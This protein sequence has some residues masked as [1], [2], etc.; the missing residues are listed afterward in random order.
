M[1][2][3]V[4]HLYYI[5]NV[6]ILKTLILLTFKSV[7]ER[8]GFEPSVR[9][10]RTLAFQASALNHSAISPYHYKVTKKQGFDLVFLAASPGKVYLKAWN[11]WVMPWQFSFLDLGGAQKVH[12]VQLFLEFLSRFEYFQVVRIQS[13]LDRWHSQKL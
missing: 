12:Q 2:Q 9:Y 7:A 10:Y 11:L 6:Y 13:Q 8:E 5:I 1:L 4:L 3:N